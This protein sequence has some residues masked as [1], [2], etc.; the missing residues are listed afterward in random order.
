MYNPSTLLDTS[1]GWCGAISS[2]DLVP[3]TNSMS[4]VPFFFPSDV[5]AICF[6][7][8]LPIIPANAS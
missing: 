4:T 3:L 1:A 5:I 8:Y 2:S 7:I 6:L